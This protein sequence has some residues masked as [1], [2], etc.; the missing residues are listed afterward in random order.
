[1]LIFVNNV[2]AIDIGP[3]S[4]SYKEGVYKITNANKCAMIA[5]LVTSDLNTSLAIV[6]SQGNQKIF[7]KFDK[8]YVPTSKILLEE[9]DYIIIIGN[10]EVSLV[11]SR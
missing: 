5:K 2:K 4:A 8:T 10:G 7:R 11:F 9:N 6:D 1:M 3:T